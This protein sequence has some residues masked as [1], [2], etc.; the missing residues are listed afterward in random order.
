MNRTTL[1][2]KLFLRITPTLL[3]TFMVIGAC[4][5]HSAT[6]E[7]NNVYDAQLIDNAN[8]LWM[9]LQDEFEE[10]GA[11]TPK[12]IEDIDFSMGNQLELN[13]DADDYADARMFRAWKSEK[14][15]V[16]SSTAFPA[17]V[18]Q[19]Q[20][21]FSNTVY[22]GE[23]W[24]IYVLPIEHTSIVIEVGEKIQLREMLVA[25]ILMNLLVPFLV[26]IPVVGLLIWFGINNGLGTIRVLVQQISNRS[27]D[28][29]SVIP[30]QNL[31]KDLSPLGKSI[32]HLLERLG[33][34][35]DAERRFAEHAAHQLRTPQAGMKLL[36]QMLNAADTEEERA[37]I[38]ADLLSSN[39]RSI[40]LIEQLLRMARVSHQPI[41]W[42]TVGLYGCLASAIADMGRVI[43]EKNL[44]LTLK[45]REDV[46]VQT[47]EVLLKLMAG[48]LVENA[49]KFTP[50]GGTIDI[51]VE[52]S[53]A[54][55][56]FSIS[57]SGPGI[58]DSEREAVFQRFYRMNVMQA[59]GTGLGLAIVAEILER[60][61]GK[62]TLK[63]PP[64]GQGL[65]VEVILSQE[66]FA[67]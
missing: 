43:T 40:Q 39:E 54:G 23:E 49:I 17:S 29:L 47:D 63:T 60:L 62:I 38:H 11:T 2:R 24:R 31:P 45:G 6:R 14:L 55:G 33:Y 13:E 36:L 53:A 32:N 25:N 48:N 19:Q 22:H 67:I 52:Q 44:N 30:V 34:S 8:V 20:T 66:K 1:T 64:H 27:A 59:D 12:Q 41:Q 56:M 3:V 57:D 5:F 58:P 65:L 37:V 9:L 42:Q 21:G 7:I 26:L 4:A 50:A 28:D 51:V 15:A 46:L 35:F 18:P 61:H 16:F 10:A